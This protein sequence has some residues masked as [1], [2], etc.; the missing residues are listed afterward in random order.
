MV[1]TKEKIQTANEKVLDITNPLGVTS[2][3]YQAPPE[4]PEM[5]LSSVRWGCG[6]GTFFHTL[7][8]EWQLVRLLWKTVGQRLPKLNIHVT[9]DLATPALEMQSHAHQKMNVHRGTI[10]NNQG[11]ET[12]QQS[13][14]KS[15]HRMEYYKAMRIDHP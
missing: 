13:I 11:Q 9:A 2:E 15:S 4:G 1:F 3:N 6:A 10:P 12:T 7:L 5:T 8:A 14:Y